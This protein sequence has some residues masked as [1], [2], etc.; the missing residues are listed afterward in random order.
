M[1]KS[2]DFPLAIREFGMTISRF[3]NRHYDYDIFSDFIDYTICCLSWEG[4]PET[5]ERLKS[6][7]KEEYPKFFDLYKCFLLT[8]QKNISDEPSFE[9]YDVLGEIYET[10]ASGSKASRLG[11]FFTPKSLCDMMAM[12]THQPAQISTERKQRVYDCASGSGRTLLAYNK[13]CPGQELYAD[14]LDPICSK[15]AAINLAIHGC[16]GQVCNMNSLQPDD[17]Y[18]GYQIN[19][20]LYTAGGIPHIV[21]ITKEQAFSWSHWQHQKN[22]PQK[23]IVESKVG[24][25]DQ[26]LIPVGQQLTFF[27]I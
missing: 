3:S 2:Q 19:P 10:I 18:F 21:P 17:W 14:D 8:Q 25:P 15:M 13:V 20:R 4:N 22:E 12:L 23:P 1:A 27:L 6:K 26:N 24:I 11:Q 16:R 7:Y 5:V 9:W